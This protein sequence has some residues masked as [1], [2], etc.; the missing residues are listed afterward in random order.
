MKAVDRIRLGC[1]NY[2]GTSDIMRGRLGIP[3]V[4]IEALEQENVAGMFTGMFE[5]AFD[6]SEMSLAE[7][8][9]YTSR[10]Q[11]E[12]VGLPVFPSRMFRHGF[13]FV[14]RAANIQKPEDLAGK[15]LGFLRWVQTAAVWVRGMLTDE[16]GITPKNSEW[17]AASLHHWDRGP[18]EE[19]VKLPGGA[20]IRTL[21]GEGNAAARGL[22]ALAQGK[23]DLLAVTESQLPAL[24]ADGAVTRLLE[25]YRDV[26]AAYFEKTKIFP[27]MHVLAMRKSLAD[28]RP[29]LPEQ[30]FRL[31]TAA[32]Q[33]GRRWQRS[34]PSLVMAW[35][36]YALEQE[37]RIFGDDPCPYGLEA[38]R[39][40]LNKFIE[41]CESQG[42]CGRNLSPEELFVPST[43]DLEEER[44]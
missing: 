25:N 15:R 6:V 3:G 38:N 14:R 10:S 19:A 11:N 22:A 4:E 9:Y 31:F 23:L 28:E 37:G 36:N 7:L 32:K 20:T 40:V 8:I 5:G 30:L 29:E 13:I 39:H 12:F 26:E 42:I 17:Y 35:K 27:I 1:R 18:A 44:A 33:H 34:L 24:L 43:W 41:Y 21:A 16:Y 2:D